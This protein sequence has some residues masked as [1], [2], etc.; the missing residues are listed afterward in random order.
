MSPS[1]NL[2]A[3]AIALTGA[4]GILGSA[5]ASALAD[6]GSGATAPTYRSQSERRAALSRATGDAET[7]EPSEP[8]DDLPDWLTGPTHD[9]QPGDLP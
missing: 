6:Q 7:A 9:F 5:A 2:A 8:A 3:V 4:V 1:T